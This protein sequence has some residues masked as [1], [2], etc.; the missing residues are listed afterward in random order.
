MQQL[1]TFDSGISLVQ[2][3][4]TVTGQ[5]VQ[6]GAV[7]S[8]ALQNI[9]AIQTVF[10]SNNGLAS[11]LKQVAQVISRAAR[12][13]EPPNFLLLARRL[14]YPQQSIAHSSRAVF[15]TQL[16]DVAFYQ[17]T[18]ELGVA[19]NVTTFTLS[20][21]SRT[22]QPGSNGGTDHAWGGHR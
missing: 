12:S 17:A 8:Q 14:R 4:S 16:S 9:P 19:S 18:Q 22:F 2:A 6:E 11:Q 10:P 15:P 21:F 7:L 20:E 1:L 5:A 13:T 3:A